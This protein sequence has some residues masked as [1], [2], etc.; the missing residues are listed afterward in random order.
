MVSEVVVIALLVV[1][2]VAV[3]K[4]IFIDVRY[5]LVLT[6]SESSVMSMT[7]MSFCRQKEEAEN[8]EDNRSKLHLALSI[9]DLVGRNTGSAL[10]VN[11]RRLNR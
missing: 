4:Y 7:S 5:L 3:Q 2:V 8:H 11:R 6:M 10:K 1:V 9:A